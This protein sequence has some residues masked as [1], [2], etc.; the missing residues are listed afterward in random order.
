MGNDDNGGAMH[1]CGQ[2]VYG[3]SLNLPFNFAVHL[4]LLKKIVW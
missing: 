4:E 1:V 3:T 2:V